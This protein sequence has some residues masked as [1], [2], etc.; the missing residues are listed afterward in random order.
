MPR[1]LLSATAAWG[2]STTSRRSSTPSVYDVAI[3]S[4][5]EP[6]TKLSRRIG[7]QVLAQARRQPA[8]VQLQAARRLQQDG[9]TLARA[10]GARGDL[11]FGGQ[12]RAGVALAAQRLGC[13]ATIVMPVTTPDPQD[14]R[15]A[16]RVGGEVVLHGDSYSDA[17]LHALRA[18]QGQRRRPSCIRSTTPT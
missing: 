4:P 2:C 15:G 17:Y 5:L 16:R 18:G 13:R 14:R 10:A 1:R 8:G 12:P 9:A 6:A 3:E 7:N 11:R